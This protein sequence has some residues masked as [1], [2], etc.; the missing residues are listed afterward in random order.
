MAKKN[1]ETVPGAEEEKSGSKVVTV[2]IALLIVFIWL[3]VFALLIKLDVGGFGSGILRPLLKDV[4][5]VNLIL[6]EATD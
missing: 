6:P 4:L 1:K 2:I 5:I 3:A